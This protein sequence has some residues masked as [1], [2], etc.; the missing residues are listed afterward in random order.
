MGNFEEN[1]ENGKGKENNEERLIKI[2]KGRRKW[3]NVRGKGLKKAEDFFVLFCFVFVFVFHFQE[4]TE[5]FS[6][7]TKMEIS[8]GKK[9]KSHREKSG[10][11][12]LPPPWKISLLH[13]CSALAEKLMHSSKGCCLKSLK[14]V[15]LPLYHCTLCNI[16]ILV[17]SW[18]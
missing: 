10:K 2:K 7:S 5:N 8:T 15:N 1:E 12:T 13:P 17:S 3:E 4:T 9:L 16:V 11:V 14:T 6:G 18:V